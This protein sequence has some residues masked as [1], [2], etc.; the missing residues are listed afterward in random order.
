MLAT[1]LIFPGFVIMFDMSVAALNLQKEREKKNQREQLMAECM[2][3]HT[4][5]HSHT[6]YF[7]AM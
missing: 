4:A 2:K 6:G 7:K 3:W 1:C 5:S